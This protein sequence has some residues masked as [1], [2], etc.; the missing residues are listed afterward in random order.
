MNVLYVEDNPMDAD[1]LI[2]ELARSKPPI[3]IDKVEMYAEAIAKLERCTPEN[4]IYDLVLTDLRLPDGNGSSLLSYIRDRELNIAVVMLTGAG[5]DEMAVAALKAGASDYVVKRG[6]YLKRMAATLDVALQRHRAEMALHARP[7]RVLYA[8]HHPSDIDLTRRHFARFAPYIHMDVVSVARDV[9]QKL[10]IPTKDWTAEENSYDV[11]LLDYHLSGMNGLELLKELLQ[12]RRVNLSVVMVTGQGDEE[13][14]LQA[15]RLGAMDYIV[16]NPGYLYKLPVVIENAYNRAQLAREQNVLRKREEYFRSLIE[17]ASDIIAVTTTEGIVQYESPSV[18]KVLGYK[19][20]DLIGTNGFQY[21][22]PDDLSVISNAALELEKNTLEQGPTVEVRVQHLDGSWRNFEMVDKII[23]GEEGETLFVTNL[24]DIT[25]RRK[26]EEAL[27]DSEKKYRELFETLQEGIWVVDKDGI[28]T[29]VNQAMVEMLGYEMD[30]MLGRPIFSFMDPTER[31]YGQ[32]SLD[33]RKLG[34]KEQLDFEFLRKDGKRIYTT[35]V[36]GPMYDNQGLYTGSIAGVID[37]TRRKQT[38]TALH[39]SETQYRQLVE[40]TPDGVLRF[41]RDLRVLFANPAVSKYVGIPAEELIGKEARDVGFAGKDIATWES[42]AQNIF[43]NKQSAEFLIEIEPPFGRTNFACHLIP[44]SNNT[45]EVQSLLAICHDVTQQKRI[46]SE[47]T[48]RLKRVEMLDAAAQ[49]LAGIVINY[50]G[51]LDEIA[52]QIAQLLGDTC[53][54]RLLSEDGHSLLPVAVHDTDHEA[55][56]FSRQLVSG[57]TLEPGSGI[58]GAVA[59]SGQPVL[60]QDGLQEDIYPTIQFEFQAYIERYVIHSLLIVPM[61]AQGRIIGTLS[62][63]SHHADKHYDLEDQV[64]LQTLADRAALAV[65]NANLYM[66]N[67]KQ[68]KL[69][70]EVNAELELRVV[71][72]TAQLEESNKELEAFAY[73][74]SHDLRA[75][76]LYMHGFANALLEDYAERLDATGQEYL[77]RISSSTDHMDRLIQ[78]LLEYS[79]LSRAQIQ[80]EPIDVNSVIHEAFTQLEAQING[81]NALI[82]VQDA[83]PTVVGHRITLTQ[84]IVN[85]VSNAIKFVPADTHPQIK[86]WAELRTA[87]V[88]PSEAQSSH[89]LFIL[90]QPARLQ[91]VRVYIEDNGIGIAPEHQERIFHIFERLHSNEEYPGNGIGLSIVRKGIDRMKGKVGVESQV[92]HGSRFWIELPRP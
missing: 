25:E 54:L 9:L 7:L 58:T 22:H 62:I 42:A 8:E 39:D 3:Q 34:I 14:A 1:L 92:H 47:R 84:I 28:T 38:A 43:K 56:E 72:R 66:E 29:F 55:A 16:K 67:L 79:R 59:I 86:I 20:E 4:L 10:P 68:A 24:H 19:P 46:E 76:L 13:I 73:S 17:N 6:D 69:L 87:E 15:I 64:L 81:R 26:V 61:R 31:A 36:T 5:N 80:L 60:I 32:E 89:N 12:V 78:D 18:E 74:V 83:I 11:L 30:E 52:G 88:T 51:A 70:R 53:I 91:M 33:R 85:L 35:M 37:I 21:V 23:A 75:P 40:N 65:S 45:G 2:R 49:S 44:E 48:E 57:A 27:R 77:Q 90:P 63:L 82:S 71:E 50:E 41:N